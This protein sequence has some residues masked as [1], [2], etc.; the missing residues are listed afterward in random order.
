MKY[1]G[2][3]TILS[4]F[5]A[6][7]CACAHAA[8]I[9][10]ETDDATIIVIRPL[11]LWSGD[12]GVLEDS[13]EAHQEK[14]AWFMIQTDKEIL[15]GNPNWTQPASNHPITKGVAEKLKSDGF[16]LPRS[17]KN[18][19]TVM[20]PVA[21]P[22]ENINSVLQ[23][24]DFAFKQ[25]TIANGN[26]DKLQAKTS[27]NKFF[28]GVLALGATVLAADKW[29]NVNAM[30]ATFGSGISEGLYNAASQYKGGMVPVVMG[31]LDPSKYAAVEIRRVTT[32][33]PDRVGQILIAYKAPKT[34]ETES[35]SMIEAVATLS[36]ANTS[37]QQIQ[38]ARNEDFKNRQSI[39]SECKRQAL[40][41]CK[42]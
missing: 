11:D 9:T 8:P 24:Q 34:T 32:P 35:A 28:G 27:R 42:E 18:S 30:H 7:C 39:W 4:A 2:E 23:L 17:S 26:P 29:G 16:K 13:L 25:A 41:E 21:V 38:A 22:P 10:L 20:P 37:T 31:S 36:G 14:T 19:F 5:L 6:V 33:T 3:K 15:F 1:L 12:K 40:D